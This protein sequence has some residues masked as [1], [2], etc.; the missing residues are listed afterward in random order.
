[1]EP[2]VVALLSFVC[3]TV[4]TALAVLGA[5]LGF[6]PNANEQLVTW[7][8]PAVLGEIVV[9]VVLYLRSSDGHRIKINVAFEGIDPNEVELTADNCRYEIR[10]LTGRQ[11][12][13]GSV[14]PD[15][16][17]GGWQIELPVDVMTDQTVS[18]TF[19][20]SDGQT[21]NVRP[22]RPYIHTKTGINN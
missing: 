9:T 18:L 10:D 21:W 8:L 14:A 4:L 17:P 20:L 3:I 11:I 2:R 13:H 22:F 6:F 16:G 7:G 19:E 12:R 1:M 5:A 15:F